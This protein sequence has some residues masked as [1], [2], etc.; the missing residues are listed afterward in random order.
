[1]N[2]ISPTCPVPFI[3]DIC[4]TSFVHFFGIWLHDE[5]I[6]RRGLEKS[7]KSAHA[8]IQFWKTQTGTVVFSI[9]DKR[10][11]KRSTGQ[12]LTFIDDFVLSVRQ[13]LKDDFVNLQIRN[14]THYS[15]K[16]FQH[17]IIII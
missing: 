2:I 4:V 17:L 13:I 12:I 11:N 1:M 9:G 3:S 10:L 6:E 15:N 16:K 8:Y 14:L 7:P 5:H